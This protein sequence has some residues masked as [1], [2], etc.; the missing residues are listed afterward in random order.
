M[1]RVWGVVV[2]VAM[3]TVVAGCASGSGFSDLDREATV[4]DVLPSDLPGYATDDLAEESVRFAGE[5]DG[6]EYYLVGRSEGGGVCVVVYRSADEWVTGCGGAGTVG[7]SGIGVN[8][9]AA[10][11]GS[12]E[13]ETGTPVGANIVVR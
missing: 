4:S 13:L 1:L 9:V 6:V 12:P 11:D 8:V 10:P 2:A 7:V 5:E 3:L